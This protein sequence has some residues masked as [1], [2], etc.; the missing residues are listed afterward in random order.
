MFTRQIPIN[1]IVLKKVER[2]RNGVSG[3]PFDVA[4]FK[5]EGALM[6]AILFDNEYHCAVLDLK[7]LDS[8]NISGRWRGDAF[9]PTLR[10]LIKTAG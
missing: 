5:Y 8:R 4:L 6:L 3:A 10:H 1:E 9:E 7:N 2:H